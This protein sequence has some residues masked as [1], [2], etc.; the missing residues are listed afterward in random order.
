[1]AVGN[2]FC[3]TA[4]SSYAGFW[5]ALAITFTPGGFAIISTIET[6]QGPSA[7]YDSFAFFIFVCEPPSSF[8]FLRFIP[9]SAFVPPYWLKTQ[10]Q[11]WFIFTTVIVIAT[12]RSNLALFFV[13]F[14]LDLVFLLLGIGYLHRDAEGGPNISVIKAASLFSLLTAFAAW[15]CALAGLLNESNRYVLLSLSPSPPAPWL[16]H[17]MASILIKHGL[18]SSLFPLFI[19]HG[20]SP[21]GRIAHGRPRGQPSN[22]FCLHSGRFRTDPLPSPWSRTILC[23]PQ[24]CVV[25][26]KTHTRHQQYGEVHTVPSGWEAWILATELFIK[27]CLLLFGIPKVEFGRRNLLI[28]FG[29]KLRFFDYFFF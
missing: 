25:A 9:G 5:I 27:F 10:T 15:Y 8:L 7:F 20:L 22:L 1:M 12:L 29:I 18:V 19:F 2:T 3:A 4:I 28:E 17:V 26:T 16:P 21:G 6:A 24:T 13:F 14:T 23:Y 11:G